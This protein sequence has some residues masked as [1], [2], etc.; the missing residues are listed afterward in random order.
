MD[1]MDNTPILCRVCR[2]K[3]GV[4]RRFEGKVFSLCVKCE[5]ASSYA[6]ATEVV[7]KK[8]KRRGQV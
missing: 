1:E 8:A 5:E 6:K 7:W 2:K 4:V 3:L